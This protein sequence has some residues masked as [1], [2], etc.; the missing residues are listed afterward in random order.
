MSNSSLCHGL[1]RHLPSDSLTRSPGTCNLNVGHCCG[2]FS[3]LQRGSGS[4]NTGHIF[5]N[6]ADCTI[7]NSFRVMVYKGRLRLDPRQ[8]AD[9]GYRGPSGLDTYRLAL[10]L[11]PEAKVHDQASVTGKTPRLAASRRVFPACWYLDDPV[12]VK[13]PVFKYISNSND[14][15][16]RVLL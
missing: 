15:G 16:Q 3:P 13:T 6:G 12:G 14:F 4:P 10:S 9:R 2:T 1:Y 5:G 11:D 8:S 7:N